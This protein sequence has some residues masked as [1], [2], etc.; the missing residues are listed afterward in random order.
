MLRALEG[1]AAD[2]RPRRQPIIARSILVDFGPIE[3]V[4]RRQ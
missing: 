1:R 3:R 4:E 2:N